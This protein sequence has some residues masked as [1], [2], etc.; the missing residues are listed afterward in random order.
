MLDVGGGRGMDAQVVRGRTALP[1]D[2]MVAELYLQAVERLAHAGL[3]QYEVSNFAKVGEKSR[4]NLR[5]WR[6][7]QYHGFGVGAHSF[8]G[9][10]RF[11]NTRD[12][13]RYLDDPANATDFREHL[14]PDEVKR[15]TI[16]LGLR[17]AA[18]LYY[19]E[20]VALCGREG[21]EWIDRG[22]REGW[23][24]RAGSRVALTPSGFLLSN[25]SISQL[26]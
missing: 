12:T 20:L 17:Q 25:D 1:E 24:T 4:H 8:L 14:G 18:G 21:I 6:R 5:Y 15:E 3:G 22:L 7:Q 9:E 13:K 26:F 10:E 23:L 19:E 16:F 11:S 2:D